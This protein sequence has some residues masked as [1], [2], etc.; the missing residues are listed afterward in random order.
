MAKEGALPGIIL[1]VDN[2]LVVEET[3]W[4]FL[5]RRR[6]GAFPDTFSPSGGSAGRSHDIFLLCFYTHIVESFFLSPAFLV[7]DGEESMRYEE[8][9]DTLCH[10]SC[11]LPLHCHCPCGRHVSFGLLE[12]HVMVGDLQV[13][14]L[15]LRGKNRD[16]GGSPG[17]RGFSTAG[18]D[19]KG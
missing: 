3:G 14:Y 10:C 12:L 18:R 17:A 6:Q 4:R 9:L 15:S 2:P 13:H 16:V 7:V 8:D 11:G 19:V 1:E 5:A